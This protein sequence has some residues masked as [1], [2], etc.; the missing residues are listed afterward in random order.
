MPQGVTSTADLPLF[1][2][3]PDPVATGALERQSRVCRSCGVDRGWVYV[4]GAYGTDSLR[5]SVCPWCIDDGSAADQFDVQFNDLAS[6]AVPDTVPVRTIAAIEQR[7][8]GFSGW[9]QE[10]WLFHCDDGAAFLGAVGWEG[11]EDLPDA[12]ES[13]RSD[14]ARSALAADDIE[15]V[16]GSLD[17]DGSATGYLFR[18]L[19]CQTHLAYADLD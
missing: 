6:S 5:D 15:A 18:C 9:Q 8:P 2:Y 1:R 14:L 17:I 7:T 13:L 4:L 19:H 16:I 11:L 10:R 3:H 12:I